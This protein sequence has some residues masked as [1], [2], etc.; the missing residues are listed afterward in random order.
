MKEKI[1]ERNGEQ[2]VEVRSEAG[3]LLFVKTKSGYELKCPR[4]KQI[5]LVTYEHMLSD[6]IQ[7]LD[8]KSQTIFRKEVKTN[9]K[10]FKLK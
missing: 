1:I 4:S 9:E 10:F 7:C 6:C 3:K 2:A 8:E 5:C